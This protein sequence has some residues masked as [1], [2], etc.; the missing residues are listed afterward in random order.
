MAANGIF[1]SGVADVPLTEVVA[2]SPLSVVSE[3]MSALSVPLIKISV[4]LMLLRLLMSRPWRQFLFTMIGVQVVV[5]IY[6]TIMQTTRCIPLSALWEPPSPTNPPK[7]WGTD[8]FR[9]SLSVTSVIT[10]VTDVVLSLTPLTFLLRMRQSR[11][12]RILIG[13]LMGLGLLASGASIAKTVILQTFD[14]SGSDHG[15]VAGLHIALCANLEE[16]LGLIAACLPCLKAL[17][18]RLL[19]RAGMTSQYASGDT[20]TTSVARNTR[21]SRAGYQRYAMDDR[22][23]QALPGPS[24]GSLTF[25]REPSVKSDEEELVSQSTKIP[26][27]S[28]SPDTVKIHKQDLST[29]DSDDYASIPRSS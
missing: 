27:S 3:V 21:N 10:I 26:G 9:I 13:L 6:V 8:A 25:Y 24:K 15:Q 12:E 23:G 2:R 16:Q 20:G 19:K 1:L 18:Q 14:S 17:F 29:G 7:C 5:A 28:G 11:K 22:P 4:T